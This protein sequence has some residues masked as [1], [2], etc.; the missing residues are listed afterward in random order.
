MDLA[1][2]EAVSDLI[3]SSTETA[4]RLANKTLHGT[5]S[6]YVNDLKES[7]VSLR[8]YVEAVVDFPDED[9]DFLTDTKVSTELQLAMD[10]LE[11]VRQS[12]R[13]GQLLR[14]GMT[15]VIAGRPNAGKSSLLNALAG[16]DAAIVT[17]VP[18]TTRD[19]LRE[20]IQIDGLPLHIVDTAGLR[21]GH[22]P[23]EREGILRA[24]REMEQADRVLWV[25]DDQ[26]D[27]YHDALD[28]ANLPDDVPV[29]LVRNKIDITGTNPGLRQTP[30]GVEISV[31]TI[32]GEGMDQLRAHM[33][34]SVDYRGPDEGLF[35]ARRRH[36]DALERTASHLQQSLQVL[37]NQAAGELLAEELRLAQNALSEITGEFLPDDLLGEIFGRFCI[38][39]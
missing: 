18:G 22:D 14:D 9:I 12:A 8:V 17:Q 10:T 39:K 32:S 16:Y 37:F 6:A 11:R 29:T 33:K 35:I 34:E 28:R 1:Q 3:E 23:V 13:Q 27:P 31:S 36:L 7:I 2:A 30:E 5:F 19:L 38:G 4:A 26:E 24:R 21:E 15:I 20:R 25:F